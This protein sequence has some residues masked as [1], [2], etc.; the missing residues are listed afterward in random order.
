[1]A[2]R[3]IHAFDINNYFTR[4]LNHL[5]LKR[6]ALAIHLQCNGPACINISTIGM[7]YIVCHF[8]NATRIILHNRNSW[9]W[10]YAC[11][12]VF[13]INMRNR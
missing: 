4:S 12:N 1:M 7:A 6:A 5:E 13:Y 11:D 2:S 10:T 9:P 3:Y 8:R